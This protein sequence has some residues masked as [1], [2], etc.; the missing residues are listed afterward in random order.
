MQTATE[1]EAIDIPSGSGL[2]GVES[3]N[4]KTG[5]VTITASELIKPSSE[6]NKVSIAEDGTLEVNA[7]TFD[8]I[9]QSE[10]DEIILSGG[11]A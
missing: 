6:A 5:A 2:S 4:G 7:L 8:K 1:W 10:D 9:L 11:G 3:V